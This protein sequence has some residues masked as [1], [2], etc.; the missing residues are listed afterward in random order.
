MKRFF[1]IPPI[2][3][4][5]VPASESSVKSGPTV[6]EINWN[7]QAGRP[8]KIVKNIILVYVPCVHVYAFRKKWFF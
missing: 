3:S 6:S 1:V 4:L 8:T 7:K 5:C 2:T